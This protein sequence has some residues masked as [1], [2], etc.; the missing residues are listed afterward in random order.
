MAEECPICKSNEI[1][2]KEEVFRQLMHEQAVSLH[3]MY[4]KAGLDYDT[5]MKNKKEEVSDLKEL[6]HKLQSSYQPKE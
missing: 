6:A 2:S 5:E 1:L 4:A 3:T